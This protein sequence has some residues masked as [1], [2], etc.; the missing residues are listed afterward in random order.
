MLMFK[1]FIKEYINITEY[2]QLLG[3]E[4]TPEQKRGVDKWGPPTEGEKISGHVIPHGQDR[5]YIPLE[6][7]DDKPVE[8][9]PD[10]KAHLEKHGY[11]ITDYKGNKAKEPKYGREIRIGKALAATNASKELVS[12]FNN[13]PN[14]A[15]SNSGK[16]GVVISRHRYD[17]AGKST[18][19]GWTSC[20]N[21]KDGCNRHYLKKHYDAGGHEA[22]LVHEHDKEAKSPLARISL[23]PFRSKDKTHTIL[24]PEGRRYGTSDHAF[25][26]TVRKWAETNFPADDDKIYHKDKRVYNDD[27][28]TV[29]SSPGALL[30][31]K[32][33]EDRESAFHADQNNVTP[34]H[35]T[36]GLNDRNEHVRNAAIRNP[37]ATPEHITKALNDKSVMVR[38]SAARHSNATPEHIT[39]ALNDKDFPTRSNAASNRNATHEHISKALN[40]KEPYVRASAVGNRNATPEHISKALNDESYQVRLSAIRNSNATHDHI[41]TALNDKNQDIRKDAISYHPN[42]TPEHISKA[43]NDKDE[44]VRR[45]AIFHPNANAEHITKVL[46][47]PDEDIS[48]KAQAASHPKTNAEHITKILNDKDEN[49]NVKKSALRNPNATAEHITQGLNDKNAYVREAAISNPNA[50]AEHIT[51]VLNNPTEENEIKKQALKH[52]NATHEH[53]T[54]ALNSHNSHVRYAAINSHHATP[55]HLEKGLKDSDRYV[56]MRSQEKINDI[57]LGNGN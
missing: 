16:L 33:S 48:V 50:N 47:N 18:D 2:N 45:A 12:T 3:E 41:T 6:H 26:H 37:N 51:K 1:Q 4:L 5:I 22:Y 38:A 30:K 46:N 11:Q 36:Q 43:L 27:Y 49:I 32:K 13:D 14:R 55:E 29:I 35:I 34:E 21:M 10:V 28:K 24:R 39:K 19:R 40:D 42:A 57:R 17:V 53:I 23:N 31:S 44:D 56:R 15:A 7:P 54:T 52:P 20:M 8:P 25:G 9:H